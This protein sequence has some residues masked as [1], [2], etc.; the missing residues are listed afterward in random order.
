MTGC[1][2]Y[3]TVLQST[4]QTMLTVGQAAADQ[5]QLNGA[6]QVLV[7]LNGQSGLSHA[8]HT[9]LALFT[10]DCTLVCLDNHPK[11]KPTTWVK[12]LS[13]R[14]SKSSHHMCFGSICCVYPVLSL[15][16]LTVHGCSVHGLG[17]SP[18]FVDVR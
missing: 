4:H 16:E 3:G 5:L 10:S 15:T 8:V 7:N 2:D 9:Y 14:K 12:L 6:G 13:E 17:E 1:A 18:E 11:A